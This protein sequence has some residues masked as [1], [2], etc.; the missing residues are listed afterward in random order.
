VFQYL[1]NNYITHTIYNMKQA[2]CTF[3]SSAQT[4]IDGQNFRRYGSVF[5]TDT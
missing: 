4:E 5:K 1:R 3:N 2:N